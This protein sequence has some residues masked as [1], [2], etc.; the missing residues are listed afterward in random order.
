MKNAEKIK[1]LKSNPEYCM[2][3]RNCELACSTR[4]L[5]NNGERPEIKKKI[6]ITFKNV[7]KSL[8]TIF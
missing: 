6:F 2:S 5:K 8:V 1:F 4:Q 7:K 3:C